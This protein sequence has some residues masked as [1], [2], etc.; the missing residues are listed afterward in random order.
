MYIKGSGLRANVTS[1]LN[2]NFA[3]LHEIGLN[4]CLTG[5]NKLCSLRLFQPFVAMEKQNGQSNLV[6]VS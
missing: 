4:E 5:L 2:Q 6:E 1:L 3:P